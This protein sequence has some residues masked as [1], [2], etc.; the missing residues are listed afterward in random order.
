MSGHADCAQGTARLVLRA[1]AV[2]A[3]LGWSLFI[4]DRLL[5]GQD[6]RN[7]AMHYAAWEEF[8]GDPRPGDD[9][10][11][12]IDPAL[13]DAARR[14]GLGMPELPAGMPRGER[15]AAVRAWRRKAAASAHLWR[16]RFMDNLLRSAWQAPTTPVVPYL[17]FGSLL[18]LPAFR[19][20]SALGESGS[21]CETHSCIAATDVRCSALFSDPEANLGLRPAP[22]LFADRGSVRWR[23]PGALASAP[24][25]NG[26]LTPEGLA[27]LLHPPRWLDRYPK[28]VQYCRAR[29]NMP[30]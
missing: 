19:Y 20:S 15:N 26:T 25:P 21:A 4:L 11:L 13:L 10:E 7:A 28:A 6:R 12:R 9:V 17:W 30:T 29:L 24:Q 18:S 8:H 23:G 14:A 2:A 16:D 27:L 5:S 3:L 22:T 1:V